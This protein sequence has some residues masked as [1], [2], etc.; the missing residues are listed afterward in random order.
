MKK[1]LLFSC[2]VGAAA[3]LTATANATNIGINIGMPTPVV[4]A[5]ALTVPSRVNV[6]TP[7]WYGKRYYDGNRYWTRDEWNERPATI[8]TMAAAIVTARPGTKRK[9]IVEPTAVPIERYP[10]A[11]AAAV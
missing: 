6:V 11:L 2:T 8:A 3:G 1:A 9:A 10:A 7:G 5:P 4:P